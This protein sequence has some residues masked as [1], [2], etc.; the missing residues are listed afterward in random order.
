MRF[1]HSLCRICGAYIFDTEDLIAYSAGNPG[2]YQVDLKG[3]QPWTGVHCV[4]KTC[5]IVLTKMVE[6][7]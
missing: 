4:C 7:S 1:N 5:I 6:S 3:E 2:L